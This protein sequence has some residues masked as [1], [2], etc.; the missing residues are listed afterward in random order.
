MIKHIKHFTIILYVLIFSSTVSCK[1]DTNKSM[2]LSTTELN[3]ILQKDKWKITKHY[4][5]G[6][7][8]TYHYTNYVFQFNANGSV[9][10]T[11]GGTSYSGTWYFGNDDSSIKLILN[12]SASPFSELNDDWLVVQQNNSIIELENISGG[13]GGTDYLTFEKI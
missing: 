11:N 8:E 5:N 9:T 2:S 12:F 4:N 10:A 3:T 1:K 6:K 13:N 7:D